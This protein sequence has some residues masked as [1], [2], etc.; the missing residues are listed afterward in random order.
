MHYLGMLIIATVPLVVT[1]GLLKAV[2]EFDLKISVG[3]VGIGL[4]ITGILLMLIS[5]KKEGT[6][7]ISDLTILDALIIGIAQAIA[8]LPGISRSGMTI[9]AGLFVGLKSTEAFNFSFIM[10]VPASVMAAVA[11]LILI[12]SDPEIMNFMPQYLV[13]F[14][15]AAIFTY[16]GL[17]IF[18]LLVVK[19]HLRYFAYYCFIIGLVCIFFL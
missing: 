1:A 3:F 9:V 10:Y 14:V 18:R 16:I 17:I 12:G 7:K 8:L 19:N 2:F 5:Y 13:S 4:I 11:S 15:M 6:K